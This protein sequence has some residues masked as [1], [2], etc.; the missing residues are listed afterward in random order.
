MSNSH[1]KNRSINRLNTP[2]TPQK[3]IGPS[4]MEGATL[5]ISESENMAIGAFSL[6]NGSSFDDKVVRKVAK[7][8][9]FTGLRLL[10]GILGY[11]YLR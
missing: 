6:R 2:G 11:R 4:Q 1:K 10:G 8:E 7:M 5:L 3:W 9:R